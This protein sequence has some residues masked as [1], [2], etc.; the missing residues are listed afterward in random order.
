LNRLIDQI[1]SDAKISDKVLL[2]KDL[3][4]HKLLLAISKD[5]YLQENLAFK[6]GTCLIKCYLG[7]YRFSEDLDFTWAKQEEFEKKSQKEIRKIVSQNTNKILKII[8]EITHQLNLGFKPEKNNPKY[9]ELGGSNKF[10]TIKIWY[11][12]EV[13]KAQ[14][15]IKVQINFLEK[16][17]YS[18]KTLRA[19]SIVKNI[20]PEEFEFLFPE[21]KSLLEAP[22]VKCY[23]IKE[24][25]AEKVRAI[26][27]RRGT[28]AR[29]FIDIFIITRK[30]K[31][32]L[33]T[34]RKQIIEKTKFMMRY[35]KYVKNLKDFRL[36]KFLMEEEE[37]LLLKPLGPGFETFLKETKAYILELIAELK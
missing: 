34:L 18:F 16:I 21:H 10:L 37:K 14:Q 12:S 22:R 23:D 30:E 26:L 9:I 1:A 32:K 7:Y 17:Y 31:I 4:L 28:K 33:A 5:E 15:F 19:E 36:D 27:T 20:S 8:E 25:L 6:G 24:I 29:D 2:E 3:Y 11:E 13:L 35:S